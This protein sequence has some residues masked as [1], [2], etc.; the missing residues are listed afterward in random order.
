MDEM[1]AQ[2]RA[3]DAALEEVD[4]AIRQL[5]EVRSSLANYLSQ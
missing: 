2:L 4:K 3:A 5:G 1:K